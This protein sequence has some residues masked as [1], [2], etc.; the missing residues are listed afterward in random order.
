VSYSGREVD[1]KGRLFCEAK[2]EEIRVPLDLEF[3]GQ[4]WITD[5]KHP[6]AFYHCLKNVRLC[7]TKYFKIQSA[8]PWTYG[9]K[10]DENLGIKANTDLFYSITVNQLGLSLFSDPKEEEKI[11]RA[12]QLKDMANE[13][14]RRS[15]LEVAR[16]VYKE[17]LRIV[18]G[19][20]YKPKG[21][22]IPSEKPETTEAETNEAE[23]KETELKGIKVACYS[24]SA[25][26]ELKL[27]N[28]GEAESNIKEGLS[29]DPKH[30]KLQ[31]RKALL[32]FKRAEFD[33]AIQLLET[34]E[35]E[36]PKNQKIKVLKT[37]IIRRQKGAKRKMKGVAKKMFRG[38]PTNSRGFLGSL[39]EVKLTGVWGVTLILSGLLGYLKIGSH[40]SFKVIFGFGTVLALTSLDAKS[41]I[42]SIY[43]QYTGR[44]S[45]FGYI[46]G[47]LQMVLHWVL[48]AAMILED[49]DH[50]LLGLVPV[51]SIIFALFYGYR[52]QVKKLK[53]N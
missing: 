51:I 43:P 16:K 12:K 11:P 1:E 46:R 38:T 24:N 18:R 3:E 26:V 10:G 15:K 19:N 7:E 52:I 47:I 48:A 14:F 22:G 13:F 32:H 49:R 23:I 28:L 53:A 41:I 42:T 4:G 5:Y 30:E 21:N 29:V 27:N 6:R 44:L 50:I 31:Y 37:R 45:T 8:E 39:T 33:E 40:R 2:N 25:L 9:T 17:V 36:F 20:K 35:T 34:I